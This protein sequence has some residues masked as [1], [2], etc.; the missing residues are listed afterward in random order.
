MMPSP[1]SAPRIVEVDAM[2]SG[3]EAADVERSQRKR[4]QNRLNQRARSKYSCKIKMFLQVL[5]VK[6]QTG[7]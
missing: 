1:K 2:P 4:R 5:L 3:A 7:F 6:H